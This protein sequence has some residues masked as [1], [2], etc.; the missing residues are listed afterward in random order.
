MPFEGRVVVTPLED[1][2]WKRW[3]LLESFRYTG[4][5]DT[6]EV[7]SGFTTDFASVPRPWVWLLPR[8]GQWTQAAVLHDYLWDQCRRGQFDW[9]DADGL[10]NRAL[11]ELG[12]P[13]LRRWVMWAAVRWAAPPSSWFK[14]GWLPFAKMLA[15]ALP[16]LA[17]ALLPGVVVL[18][19]LVAGYLLELVAYLPL[20]HAPRSSDKQVHMPDGSDILSS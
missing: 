8:Y 3:Q 20:R 5:I 14:R 15:I 12:V 19:A 4:R 10:F 9:Y 11:R 1:G 13:Y 6:F 16:A 2:R 18:I 17:F 7:P